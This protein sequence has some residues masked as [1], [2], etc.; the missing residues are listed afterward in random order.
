MVKK[1]DNVC[2]RRYPIYIRKVVEEEREVGDEEMPTAE[3]VEEVRD[4]AP[5]ALLPHALLLGLKACA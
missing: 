4:I 1:Q 3:G 2:S 5:W